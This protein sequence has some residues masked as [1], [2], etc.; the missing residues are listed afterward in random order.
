MEARDFRS[1]GRAAQEELR[2]RALFLVE[3]QGLSQGRAAQ[4]VGVHRQTVNTWVKRYRERG[5]EGVL[6][7]RRASPRRGKG[8]LTA[9]EADQVRGWIADGT[10]AGPGLP[11]AF[12]AA[13]AVREL[14]GRR[15]AKR[16][17]LSTVRLYLQRWGMTPQKPLVRAKERSPEAIR[18]WAGAGLPGDRQAGRGAAGGD[19]LGRR[20]RRLQPGPDR[21][22]LG[23][24]GQ[25]PGDRADGEAD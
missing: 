25:N 14:I 3:R 23:T 22:L 11:F 12:W 8:R 10:A 4:L 24:R 9:E 5:E 13:R 7:G 2:R 16:L 15:F 1:I 17:G 6:D 21:P 19:P 20:D 18:A